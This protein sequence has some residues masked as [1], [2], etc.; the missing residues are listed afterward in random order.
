MGISSHWINKGQ[1]PTLRLLIF[2]CHQLCNPCVMWASMSLICYLILRFMIHI[3]ITIGQSNQGNEHL[4]CCDACCSCKVFWWP[5]SFGDG[6]VQQSSTWQ[7]PLMMLTVIIGYGEQKWLSCSWTGV[8]CTCLWGSA[9]LCIH[10]PPLIRE[11]KPRTMILIVVWIEG[12]NP[13]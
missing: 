3:K 5:R 9:Q 11:I 8:R 2:Y 10:T 1:S 7:K 13:L 6:E 4:S 12:S